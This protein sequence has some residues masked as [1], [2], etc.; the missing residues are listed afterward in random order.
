MSPKGL[1]DIREVT[2]AR[3]LVHKTP[4]LSRPAVE[5]LQPV[6]CGLYYEGDP[7]QTLYFSQPSILSLR[8]WRLS[9]GPEGK[10]G[11]RVK[12]LPPR[13]L[14]R[15]L[16]CPSPWPKPCPHGYGVE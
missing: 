8:T 2:K 6:S 14:K 4:R 15:D 3:C 1:V 16:E 13:D 7:R 5:G 12:G 10:Q 9:S 11:S